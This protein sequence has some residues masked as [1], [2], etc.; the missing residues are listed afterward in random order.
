MNVA[1]P[2]LLPSKCL[3]LY[4]RG[5][6]LRPAAEI[7]L[8]HN[9]LIFTAILK[10]INDRGCERGENYYYFIIPKS[11]RNQKIFH[12]MYSVSSLRPSHSGRTR[13]SRVFSQFLQSNIMTYFSVH[14]YE[15]FLI[16]QIIHKIYVRGN[17]KYISRQKTFLALSTYKTMILY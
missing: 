11:I 12:V 6:Q 2:E 3:M 8:L 5:R 14:L 10:F 4:I 9:L 17:L 13:F 1:F 7:I 16:L 15:G